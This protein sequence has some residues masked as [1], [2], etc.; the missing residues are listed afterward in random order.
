MKRI[1]VNSN[2][3]LSVGYDAKL[4]VLEVELS[5]K[6]VYQF[7]RVSDAVYASLMSA[8][9]IT[10]YFNANFRESYLVQEI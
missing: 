1:S 10:E 3:L 8:S 4:Q 9:N 6:R 2:E 5:N 7:V